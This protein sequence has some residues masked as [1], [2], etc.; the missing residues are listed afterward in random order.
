MYFFTFSTLFKD[1]YVL[2]L[3]F[4]PA[5][6]FMTKGHLKRDQIL[7]SIEMEVNPYMIRFK[8]IIQPK[9]GCS[10]LEGLDDI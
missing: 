8:Q 10:I 4:T 3:R 1:M 6:F 5:I 7:P 9:N 2:T